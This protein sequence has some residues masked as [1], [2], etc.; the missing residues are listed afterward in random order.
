M[1]VPTHTNDRLKGPEWGV[2][3]AGILVGNLTPKLSFAGIAVHHVGE[4]DY[5]ITGTHLM[6]YYNFESVPGMTLSYNNMITYN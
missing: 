4:N 2:G 1:S 6:L 3:L 5:E